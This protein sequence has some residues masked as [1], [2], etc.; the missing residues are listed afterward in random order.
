MGRP[1][2]KKSVQRTVH[3]TNE[4]HEWV[5]DQAKEERRNFSNMLDLLLYRQMKGGSLR[6]E[7]AQ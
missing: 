5:E 4:V 7:V 3:I 6:K 1:R 2:H